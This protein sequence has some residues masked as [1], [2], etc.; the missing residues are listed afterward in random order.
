MPTSGRPVPGGCRWHGLAFHR[1]RG[2]GM[3]QAT[4]IALGIARQQGAGALGIARQAHAQGHAVAG[5]HLAEY[6]RMARTQPRHLSPGPGGS[7]QRRWRRADQGRFD[8]AQAAFGGSSQIGVPAAGAHPGAF[9]RARTAGG[10]GSPHHDHLPPGRPEFGSQ[11]W[12]RAFPAQGENEVN[13]RRLD[14]PLHQFGARHTPRHPGR[15]HQQPPCA[16][17]R[18]SPDRR[19]Q[20]QPK[21]AGIE[22]AQRLQRRQRPAIPLPLATAHRP[23][24]AKRRRA[25]IG[26]DAPDAVA[27]RCQRPRQARGQRGLARARR[28]EQQDPPHPACPDHGKQHCCVSDDRKRVCVSHERDDGAGMGTIR[29][30]KHSGRAGDDRRRFRPPPD[31]AASPRQRSCCDRRRESSAAACHAP[32][33][34]RTGRD[35]PQTG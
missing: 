29:R 17:L 14:Q 2:G 12:G 24:R 4:G 10:G 26:A 35:R 3:Q 33:W 22:G 18:Q 1:Q 28:A 19:R 31:T 30:L 9:L 16:P 34:R 7:R 11:R 25:G 20:R 6:R 5:E 8:P 21:P 15:V 13:C 27:N 32:G 23:R